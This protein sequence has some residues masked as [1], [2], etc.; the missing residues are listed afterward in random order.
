MP[1]FYTI[2]ALK[3]FPFFFGGGAHATLSPVSYAFFL[4]Y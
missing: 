2:I 3:Y 4:E 1:V